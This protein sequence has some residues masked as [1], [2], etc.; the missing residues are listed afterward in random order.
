MACTNR[1]NKKSIQCLLAG[2]LLV[3]TIIQGC[4]VFFKSGYIKNKGSWSYVA[5]DESSWRRNVSLTVD[6]SSFKILSNVDFAKDKLNVFYKGNKILDADSA[7]FIVLDKYGYS[8]DS[9]SVFI[10]QYKIINANPN[11]FEIIVPPYSRD[12]TH[13]F[14]GTLP[15]F[16][17]GIDDFEVIKGSNMKG[18]SLATEFIQQNPD[19]SFIDVAVYPVVVRGYGKAKTE[20]ERFD[21]FTRIEIPAEPSNGKK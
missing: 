1:S 3:V 9:K 16:C 21:G 17:N 5:Y 20:N 15:I 8:K 4:S 12:D 7:S 14:C 2:A 18:Y 10:D 6:S 19:F 11:K 13:V